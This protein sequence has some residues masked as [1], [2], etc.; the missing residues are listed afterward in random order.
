M[1]KRAELN[2]LIEVL[3]IYHSCVI[4]MNIRGLYNWNSGYEKIGEIFLNYQKDTFQVM[5]RK[6]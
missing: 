1:I 6:I 2:N 4:E 5:E 3:F